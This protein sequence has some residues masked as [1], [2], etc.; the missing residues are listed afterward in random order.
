ML[1]AR[2]VTLYVSTFYTSRLPDGRPLD[3]C[4][5]RSNVCVICTWS[6]CY[7]YKDIEYCAINPTDLWSSLR[8]IFLL[9]VSHI[10]GHSRGFS[11]LLVAAMYLIAKTF[12]DNKHSRSKFNRNGSF[13]QTAVNNILNLTHITCSM[14]I[15]FELW[16]PVKWTIFNAEF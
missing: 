4:F 9:K 6:N 2:N 11:A 8:S 10:N 5:L 13:L 1:T 16:I 14:W 12:P 15:M 7:I 3:S